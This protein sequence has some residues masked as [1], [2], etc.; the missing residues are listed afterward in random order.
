MNK[1]TGERLSVSHTQPY[2]CFKLLTNLDD[3]MKT[4]VGNVLEDV[5]QLLG[6]AQLDKMTG[7]WV[8]KE[9]GSVDGVGGNQIV[10][11]HL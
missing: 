5:R 11:I 10:I 9:V 6:P 3:N 2:I 7:G 1:G 4:V 8:G